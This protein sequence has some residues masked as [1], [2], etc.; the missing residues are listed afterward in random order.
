MGK[1]SA[2]YRRGRHMGIA[3]R[4]RQKLGGGG[5]GRRQEDPVS[6]EGSQGAPTQDRE[7][8]RGADKQ[9]GV[10]LAIR[11]AIAGCID[12][13]LV[14]ARHTTASKEFP[15]VVED[16]LEAIAKTKELMKILN[17]L[18]VQQT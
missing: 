1:Y 15:I 16:K 7:D 12:R 9:E 2:N 3:I 4:P 11:S 6:S 17:A 10:P 5:A 18:G 13:P 8:N 14:K